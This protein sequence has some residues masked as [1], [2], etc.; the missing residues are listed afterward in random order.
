M[1]CYNSLQVYELV[2]ISFSHYCEKARWALDRASVP[3]RETAF[4]PALHF[5]YAAW[6]LRGSK[7]GSADRVSS[8]F[9]TPLLCR[10][11]LRVSDSREIARYVDTTYGDGSLFAPD[12]A[13]ALDREYAV[14]LGPH[15]RRI[16][17]WFGLSDPK[18]LFALADANVSRT[19]AL[20]FRGFFPVGRR[21]L[22]RGMRVNPE[23]FRRSQ[24]YVR[25]VADEVA[26][27]L[28]DGRPYLCGDQFSIADLG[29]ASMM[30][31]AVLP[32][33]YGVW[34]PPPEELA[35][36]AREIVEE[37]RAHP[38]GAFTLRMFREHR[39]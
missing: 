25:E 11:S 13:E 37:Y 14:R 39:P 24:D 1:A 31:P 36:D 28:S 35:P 18:L 15:T 9:S 33:E 27:R 10:D 22:G 38:A 19:Q 6:K 30:A 4:M 21:M 29:F 12:E 26:E 5:P 16:V 7:A 20:V 3:Y 17:Y 8:R 2:T 32:P 23:G 34:L